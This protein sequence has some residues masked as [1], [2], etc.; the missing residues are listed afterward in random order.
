MTTSVCETSHSAKVPADR[1]A[2]WLDAAKSLDRRA[3]GIDALSGSDFGEEAYA[4][5]ELA[6]VASEL[7][8]MAAEAQSGGDHKSVWVTAL[9][10]ND[11]RAL[12]EN[13]RTYQHCGICGAKKFS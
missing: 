3:S 5:R 1:I 4:V 13:G 8:H 6:A 9:G 2:G 10:G 7:R 12:D 11:E